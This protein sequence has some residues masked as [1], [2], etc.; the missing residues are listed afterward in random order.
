M[1]SR[2]NI[3]VP[4]FHTPVLKQCHEVTSRY[5]CHRSCH[6]NL[7]TETFSFLLLSTCCGIE[8]RWRVRHVEHKTLFIFALC[9][10]T[11]TS[12]EEL[13]NRVTIIFQVTKRL[14]K[15]T[16]CVL[17]IFRLLTNTPYSTFQ[18]GRA[19]LAREV[20]FSRHYS[21]FS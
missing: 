7:K 15:L 2:A 16:K 9:Y 18:M 10:R 17:K 11:I 6:S 3:L 8:Q 5:N 1:F 12:T 14:Q 21:T 20:A 4:R 19:S 13:S